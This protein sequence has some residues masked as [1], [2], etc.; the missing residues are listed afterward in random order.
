ML[1][2][3]TALCLHTAVHGLLLDA[4]FATVFVLDIHTGASASSVSVA[5]SAGLPGRS[6][7]VL[8]FVARQTVNGEPLNSANFLPEKKKENRLG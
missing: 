4:V 5:L 1:V 6:D 3:V 2:A 8:V 7:V